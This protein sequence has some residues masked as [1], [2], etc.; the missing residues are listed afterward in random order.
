V[1]NRTTGEQ[2]N[3]TNA[4]SRS[5]R[6]P[7]PSPIQASWLIW[8][9]ASERSED[10]QTFVEHL[11]RSDKEIGGAIEL[12]GAFQDMMSQRQ[13]DRLGDWL[14]NAEA[15]SVRELRGLAE[16]LRQ[17]QAAVAEALRGNWSN[18][19]VEGQVNRLKVIKRQMYGRAGFPLLR[20]RVLNQ[21]A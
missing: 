20:A 15:S 1:A 6:L 3:A 16:G 8:R 18:G 13:P 10:E 7:T 14:T 11:C 9:P 4:T 5:A 19:A 17:D 12:A 2:D 21:V